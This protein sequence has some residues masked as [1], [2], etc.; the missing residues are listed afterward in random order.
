MKIFIG[1]S[2]ESTDAMDW[3]ARSLEDLGH[4]PV[5]WNEFGLF[6]PGEYILSRLL[7]I[8]QAVDAAIF[9]FAETDE[10]W[11]RGDTLWQPR[12]NVLIE[13]GLFAGQLGPK[14]CIICTEGSPKIST[15]LRGLLVIEIGEARRN[16]ASFELQK[17]ISGLEAKPVDPKPSSILL[18]SKV[19]RSEVIETLRPAMGV[20]DKFLQIHHDRP[21]LA[22]FANAVIQK[23]NK[24]L[25][26][27]LRNG[28]YTM[29][30]A[31][32]T[33]TSTEAYVKQWF[34][35]MEHLNLKE[36]QGA[37]F[38]T[39]SN[40]VIWSPPYFGR[41]TYGDLQLESSMKIC[42]IFVVPSDAQLQNKELAIRLRNVLRDYA[43]KVASSDKEGQAS[44]E[45]RVQTRIYVCADEDEY[46]AHFIG[47]DNRSDNFAIWRISD[48]IKLLLTVDYSLFRGDTNFQIASITFTHGPDSH[49]I[50]GKEAFFRRRWNEK[51]L[52]EVQD[53]LD[54]LEKKLSDPAN[55][56]PLMAAGSELSQ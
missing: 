18:Q 54:K 48:T 52:I 16:R 6:P 38:L 7:E 42:R 51:S 4:Q 9:I 35:L 32:P 8:S 34:D 47:D 13:W 10:I 26:Q 28:T 5:K 40:I 29:R 55:S 14:K 19:L 53:Y 12:D 27:I 56:S 39:M 17:W 41:T 33:A 1:S 11:Y 31:T 2:R 50:R 43:E 20:P 37:E 24:D 46:R 22:E 21:M 45:N 23:A 25:D 49:D 36:Y 15:D 3:V 44:K 30:I